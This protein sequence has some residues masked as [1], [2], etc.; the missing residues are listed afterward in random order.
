MREEETL[1]RGRFVMLVA[2]AAL[3]A[4]CESSA[5]TRGGTTGG[6]AGAAAGTTTGGGTTGAPAGAVTSAALTPEARIEEIGDTVYFAFDSHT[7]D[8]T[9]RALVERQAAFLIANP[10]VTLTIEGHTD[11]RGTREYNLALGDRR[12]NAVRDYMITLGVEPARLRTISYG[13]ERPVAAGSTEQAW[14]QNRRAVSVV[15]GGRLAS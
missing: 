9:A 8:T 15:T 3:V 1:M 10:S 5:P 11:E 6:D 13:E 14:S 12:S 2:A 4:A 7:L